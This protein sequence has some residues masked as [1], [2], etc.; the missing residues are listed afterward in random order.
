[1]KN[2]LLVF[3]AMLL[4]QLNGIAQENL[5][6]RK[7]TVDYKKV[8]LQ[9]VLTDLRSRYNIQFSYSNSELPLS[10]KVHVIATNEP[11]SVVFDKIFK[12]MQINYV[13]VGNKIILK[14]KP[15]DKKSVSQL[16]VAEGFLHQTIR[17]SVIDKDTKQPIQGA[18]IVVRNN[19]FLK[20]ALSD[21]NGVFNIQNV[22]LGRQEVEITMMGYQ[23]IIFPETLV[24]SAKENVLNIEMVSDAVLL[25]SVTVKHHRDR[26]KSSNQ[27]A[28]VSARSFTVEETNR[29]AASISD[30]AR[31]ALSFAGVA[32]TDDLSNELVI[33]GN[34]PKGLLWRLEGI[35]INNPNHFTDEGSS[36]GGVS[37]ISSTMLDNSDFYTGAFAAEYG[38]ALSGV[39]DLKFRKGNTEK[40]E[41]SF[42]AGLLGISAS[43][44][45]PI[46]TKTKSSY[47]L[48]YRY[49]TL[50]LLRHIGLNPIQNGAV[51]EY[52]DLTFHINVPTKTAGTFSLFGIGGLSNQIREAE[53]NED[54]WEGFGDKISSDFRYKSGSVGLKHEINLSKNSYLRSIASYSGGKILENQDTLDHQYEKQPFGRDLYLNQSARLSTMLNIKV[55]NKNLLRTGIIY[56][57][58][59]FDYNSIAT[60]RSQNIEIDYLNDKGNTSL[61]QSYFQWRHRLSNRVSFN[62]GV[63][64]T[65]F[66]L[67]KDFTIE[68]R[69]GAEWAINNKHAISFGAGLHSRIEPLV[70]YFAKP[71]LPDGTKLPNNKDLDLTKA[72]HVV[73]GYNWRLSD[74]TKLKV[75]GYYQHLYDVPIVDNPQV[76]ISSLNST[77]GY[78]LYDYN[79]GTLSNKGKGRN[80]GIEMSV[81]RSLSKGYYFLINNSLYNSLFT[82]GA[83]K[84]FNTRFN[85]NHIINFVGGKEW[86]T[87]RNN[88]NL[89]GINT[90]FTWTGGIRYSP[91]D[92]IASAEKKETIVFQDKINTLKTSDYLRFDLSFSYRIN[93]AG[94]A[95]SFF[96]DIQNLLNR[97]NVAG[98]YYDVDKSKIKLFHHAGFVPNINYRIEF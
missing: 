33:R 93:K 47:L 40:R 69:T 58:I 45:G 88:K 77:S 64:A 26:Q 94:V 19:N 46:N 53:K 24:G 21:S 29:Y 9:N 89:F 91:I 86:R 78:F 35:E 74:Y 97:Q 22:T 92:E 54:K 48:N 44:E 85:G 4:L 70:L 72:A 11:A 98:M 41:Y 57:H 82:A 12:P 34:S 2:L 27:M 8:T 50:G 56:N 18:T 71:T 1:M 31:M 7:L 95:H 13:L 79:Y 83:G 87:G 67:S 65:W 60:R 52:Q 59:F 63:H 39:F 73:L 49:S 16:K 68:P 6:E 23:K 51:P 20:S 66:T 81:E 42:S 5:L 38:N 28:T 75:E 25:E 90:K 10:E 17:G 37:M 62:T 80:Y 32:A 76:S 36:G 3:I 43:A 61:M 15:S 84:E 55:D 14:A 30:P 96:I